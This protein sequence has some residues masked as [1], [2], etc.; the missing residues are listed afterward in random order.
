MKRLL[1][2]FNN[3]RAQAA[4]NRNFHS[5]MHW[6]NPSKYTVRTH[7]EQ[8]WRHGHIH[9]LARLFE[10]VWIQNLFWPSRV[11]VILSVFTLVKR[12]QF[13][14]KIIKF[15]LYPE[16]SLFVLSEGNQSCSVPRRLTWKM[17]EFIHE[18]LLH[19]LV[20]MA[21]VVLRVGVLVVLVVLGVRVLVMSGLRPFLRLCFRGLG[22]PPHPDAV[23]GQP[24]VGCDDSGRS[25]GAVINSVLAS[26]RD[27][28]AVSMYACNPCVHA[29][30]FQST[31]HL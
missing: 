28:P 21:R 22:G 30:Q 29:V 17:A 31:A 11:R 14:R 10:W 3:N 1:Q 5:F 25:R 4:W 12:N 7:G 18:L 8:E 20:V 13:G 2:I 6:Y 15:E 23:A 19:V 24:H 26:G 27:N 16:V 9:W